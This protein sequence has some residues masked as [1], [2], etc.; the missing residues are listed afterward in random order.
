MGKELPF[1]V[2]KRAGRPC[3]V[4]QFKDEAGVYLPAISTKQKTEGAAIETAFKWLREGIPQKGGAV[5]AEAYKMRDAIRK[6]DFTKA[7]AE[8]LVQE[9]QRRGFIKKAVFHESREA[10]DFGA[11]LTDFWTW[12]KSPYIAEKQRKQHGIHQYYVKSKL[13]AVHKYWCCAFQGKELG[14][15]TENDVEAFVKTLETKN[16]SSKRK[17]EIIRAGTIA[18]KWAYKKR[19]IDEDVTRG[20]VWFAG[21]PKERQILSPELAQAVFSVEWTD[22][23]IKLANLIAALSGLRAGEIQ[24]LRVQDLGRNCL[25][26]RHSWNYIDGLKCPKNK[27][28]RTVEFPFPDI[29]NALKKQAESNPDYSLDSFIFWSTEAQGQPIDSRH[30]IA[31]LRAAL[32][33]AGL[34][35]QS[36]KVYAFHAWRHFY[37]AY[38]IKKVNKELL[39]R[40]TGHKTLT[41]LEH[42]ADHETAGD[43][44]SIRA[45]QWEAFGGLLP[46][47]FKAAG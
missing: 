26:I 16:L 30:F 38:M 20:L 6:A 41:M 22:N 36:A 37:T 3:Y 35:E 11:F 1:S 15:V 27:E 17:N 39:Q 29:I 44:E 21:R 7:D 14:V 47:V 31:G 18:L 12:E 24:G 42:Y 19:L 4:V 13:C 43:R 25:Y 33:K 32:K 34:S 23:R 46:A 5:S 9:L 2:F 10:V 45:A 8:L 28:A 40:Q